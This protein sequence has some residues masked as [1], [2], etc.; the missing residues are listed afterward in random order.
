MFLISAQKRS[1]RLEICKNCEHYL[2]ST[3]SCGTLGFGTE[4]ELENGERIKLCGCIMPIKT[5]LRISSCPLNK[6]ASELSKDD[7]NNMKILL[8]ELEGA[9]TISGN[10][11]TQLTEL[12]N[13]ASGGNKK[14]SSCNSCVRKTIQELKEFIKDE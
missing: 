1:N 13:K 10:Q 2:P 3:K 4:I 8:G 6:W 11:N 7:L 12:W 9:T 5:G 14:V